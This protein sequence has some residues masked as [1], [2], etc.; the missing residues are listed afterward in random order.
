MKLKKILRFPV[1]AFILIWHGINPFLPLRDALPGMRE[2][3]SEKEK[4]YIADTAISDWASNF[5]RINLEM[6]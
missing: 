3:L 2:R 1:V 5:I 4:L 6:K